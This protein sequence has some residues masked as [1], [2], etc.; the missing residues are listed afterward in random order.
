M[1]TAP[2]AYRGGRGA[3]L[4]GPGAESWSSLFSKTGFLISCGAC[5][6]KQGNIH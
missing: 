1:K 5:F 6:S 2:L 3:I 4:T